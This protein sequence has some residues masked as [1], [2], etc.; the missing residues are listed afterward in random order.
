MLERVFIRA[1]SSNRFSSSLCKNLCP[2]SSVQ[3]VLVPGV[4]RQLNDQKGVH[5]G[6]A[7]KVLNMKITYEQEGPA[8]EYGEDKGINLN[9]LKKPEKDPCGVCQTGVG[10]NAIFCGGCL[11]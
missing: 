5:A 8:G 7:G 9:L 6:T 10:R 4:R 11:C 2:G 1:L 3:P